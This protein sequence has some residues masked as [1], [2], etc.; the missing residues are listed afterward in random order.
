MR[1]RCRGG[2][3]SV[4]QLTHLSAIGAESQQRAAGA[5][6]AALKAGV[7]GKCGLQFLKSSAW[8]EYSSGSAAGVFVL[9][10]KEA[11]GR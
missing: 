8:N 10:P 7:G 5:Q 2:C 9:V 6:S 4:N 11:S 3:Y 1:E